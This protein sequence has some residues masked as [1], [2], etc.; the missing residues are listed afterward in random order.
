M[1]S[2]GRARFILEAVRTRT[3]S[4]KQGSYDVDTTI[5]HEE[6]P[7]SPIE[8]FREATLNSP[9]QDSIVQKA[10]K[11]LAAGKV[12]TVFAVSVKQGSGSKE[13][14]FKPA[15]DTYG[16]AIPPAVS[17][18]PKIAPQLCERSIATSKLDELLDFGVI[19]KTHPAFIGNQA[20]IV[21]E[22]VRGIS[23]QNTVHNNEDKENLKANVT[24]IDYDSPMLR[25]ALICLQLEDIIAGQVDRTAENYIVEIGAEGKLLGVK[26]IDNDFSFGKT[27]KGVQQ[28]GCPA[29]VSYPPIIDEKMRDQVN[30]LT[31]E[32]LERIMR[33]SGLNDTEEIKQAK[34]RLLNLKEHIS[35]LDSNSIIK[36]S[37]WGEAI[38]T[39]QLMPYS[40][41][42]RNSYIRRD[43]LAQEAFKR[44]SGLPV[45]F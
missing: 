7:K 33:E 9:F 42:N 23:I 10:R 37:Q 12:N 43:Q 20:G 38:V 32:S 5:P 25:R 30:A 29:T 27:A 34:R 24:S 39:K 2:V 14:V 8:L 31:P 19:T 6:R 16:N 45:Y 35:K 40:P 36:P 1:D 4:S 22:R 11:P 18:I 26:G 17:G 28:S 13:M 15:V 21:M 44:Q 41:T 3:Q